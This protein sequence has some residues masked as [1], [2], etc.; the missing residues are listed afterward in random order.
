MPEE[1]IG[2]DFGV[3]TKLLGGRAVIDVTYFRA[4]LTNEIALAC[5]PPAFIC[6]PFN[7][8]GVSTRS[9]VEIA[10]RYAVTPEITLGGAFTYLDAREDTGLEEV[11]R[12]RHSGRTDV[13]YAFHLGRG[14]FNLAAIYNGQTQD[15]VTTAK[16]IDTRTTLDAYWLI[17]AAAS[18]KLQPGVEVFGRV[19]NLLDQP[20]QEV[21]GYN[22]TPGIAAFAGVKLTFG[23]EEGIG[24]SFAK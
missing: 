11:R 3:E 23:G 18:Y 2:W 21:F 13:N 5:P 8:S 20:Y 9:G 6:T 12:P 15:L 22:A 24:G 19:E 14:N 16:F 10:G 4:D 1:S 7:R 17:R